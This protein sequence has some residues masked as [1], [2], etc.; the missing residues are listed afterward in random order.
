M[1]CLALG[2]QGALRPSPGRAVPGLWT[3]L[4]HNLFKAPVTSTDRF[5]KS[6][7]PQAFPPVPRLPFSPAHHL[8]APQM[9]Q[10]RPHCRGSKLSPTQESPPSG[11][12]TP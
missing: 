1:S 8:S 11:A 2:S 3:E 5:I 9:A 6:Q 4:V 12:Q 10:V 7:I